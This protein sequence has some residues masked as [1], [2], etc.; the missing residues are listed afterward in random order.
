MSCLKSVKLWDNKI[1][2]FQIPWEICEGFGQAKIGQTREAILKIKIKIKTPLMILGMDTGSISYFSC[3]RLVL[4][5][6]ASPHQP[7]T[8]NKDTQRTLTLMSKSG[9][10]VVDFWTGIPAMPCSSVHRVLTRLPTK[11]GSKDGCS[12]IG[13]FV[14]S[15]GRT[16]WPSNV[17]KGKSFHIFAVFHGC[18][19][20]KF[21]I[22]A[23]Q[24]RI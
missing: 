14:G 7:V 9:S 18:I 5:P 20:I 16:Q 6:A 24:W 10:T 13:E 1:W 2:A 3:I 15:F 11:S 12:S 23:Y 4:P 21:T 8:Q 17:G 22:P 19:F